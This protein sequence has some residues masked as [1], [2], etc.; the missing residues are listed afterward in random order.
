M[1]TNF[2]RITIQGWLYFTRQGSL[3][4]AAVLLLA[5]T[6][7]LLTLVFILRGV[8]DYVLTS[9]KDRLDVSV[10][11]KEEA[12]PEDIFGVQDELKKLSEVKEIEYVSPEQALERFRERYKDDETIMESLE[13]V[14]GNPLLA[15]LNI[16][17]WEGKDYEAVVNFLE[18]SSYKNL[19]EAIDYRQNK[20][21]IDRLYSISSNVVLWGLILSLFLSILAIIIVFNTVRLAII[22]ARKEIE[23]M[24]LVGAG[25]MFVA[26]PFMVQGA[27]MGVSATLLTIT[28]FALVAIAAG[29]KLSVL[30]P[31]FSLAN[32]YFSNLGVLFLLLIAVGM[33]IGVLSSWMAVRKYLQ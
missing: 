9:F 33:S 16:R 23:T 18:A 11:F 31:G 17:V 29:G 2:K 6:L 5:S 26:G 15:A 32:Y 25:K 7:S 10:Y 19:I 12:T 30:L 13:S 21:V 24:N 22:Y 28:F 27:L 8:T 4:V 20:E 1:F 14:G 3:T